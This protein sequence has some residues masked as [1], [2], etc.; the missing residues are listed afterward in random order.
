LPED[1][2]RV[3]GELQYTVEINYLLLTDSSLFRNNLQTIFS[4]R[5]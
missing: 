2:I 1:P 4:G 5:Q 3:I